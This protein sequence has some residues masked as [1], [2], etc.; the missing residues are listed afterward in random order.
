MALTASS[1]RSASACTAEAKDRAHAPAS[2]LRHSTGQEHRWSGQKSYPNLEEFMNFDTCKHWCFSPPNA[3]VFCKHHSNYESCTIP[4]LA[5]LQMSKT[6]FTWKTSWDQG[7]WSL[8]S[9]SQIGRCSCFGF[10]IPVVS[11]KCLPKLAEISLLGLGLPQRPF[12]WLV[13]FPCSRPQLF[14]KCSHGTISTCRRRRN[15]LGP[16]QIGQNLKCN[17]RFPKNNWLLSVS[18]ASI[19][20]WATNLEKENNC[21]QG[22]SPSCPCVNTAWESVIF[23]STMQTMHL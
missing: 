5:L 12:C 16:V 6:T 17:D 3:E 21:S 15:G 20:L 11:Q 19:Q 2:H 18:V 22:W 13:G 10:G 4:Q 23:L 1:G 7:Q 9:M 8:W 14:A